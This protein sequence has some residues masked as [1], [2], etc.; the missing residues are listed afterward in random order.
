MCLA[1]Q[2][3][4]SNGSLTIASESQS[5]LVPSGDTEKESNVKEEESSK[6]WSEWLSDLYPLV[7]ILEV[8]V[9]IFFNFEFNICG[10]L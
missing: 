4:R 8:Q 5:G 1:S 9:G 10:L 2:D 3:Q 7:K 6:S